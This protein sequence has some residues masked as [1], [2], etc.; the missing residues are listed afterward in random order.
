MYYS[1]VLQSLKNKKLYKGSTSNLKE[2]IFCHNAGK[3]KY[4][5]KYMPWVLVY[6]EEFNTRTEAI[7]REKFFKS[8]KGREWLK[9]NLIYKEGVVGSFP[10]YNAV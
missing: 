4:T 2:R 6:F 10:D 7:Q 8:G 1:Y 5:S 9:N 3:V